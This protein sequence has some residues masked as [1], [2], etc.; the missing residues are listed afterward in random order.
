MKLKKLKQAI[1][2]TATLW[3]TLT[4]AASS[5]LASKPIPAPPRTYVLDEPHVLSAPISE[6]L[7]SLLSQHNRLTGEQI[8]VA[9]FD[10]LDGEDPVSWTNQVFTQ[11]KIGQREKDNGVLLAL[12]WKEHRSRIEIG[13]GLEPILTDAKAKDILANYLAPELRN[14]HP[15][16][17]LSLATLQILKTVDS[18]LLQ[19]RKAQEILRSGGFQG[20]WRPTTSNNATWTV[21]LILGFILLVIALNILTTASAHFSRDGWYRPS[22]WP[23][24]WTGPWPPSRRRSRGDPSAGGNGFGGDRIGG[25]FSGGG[26]LSGGGGASGDW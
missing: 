15:D 23:H 12:Y 8:V 5:S 6:S 26:G 21:W 20:S 1:L 25:G 11:W 14:N 18:P 22:P 4:S 17:A 16:R 9:I 7:Q 10:S 13:Y 3:I 2:L 19:D 24:N